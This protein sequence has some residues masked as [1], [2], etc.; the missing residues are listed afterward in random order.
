M[1]IFAS[2]LSCNSE[3]TPPQALLDGWAWAVLFQLD[4]PKPTQSWLE[5][6][7]LRSFPI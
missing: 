6:R 1:Q 3:S 5:Q 4:A 7:R 2:L